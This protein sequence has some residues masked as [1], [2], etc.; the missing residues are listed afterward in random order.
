MANP[1]PIS[2][3]TP[4]ADYS[5]RVDSVHTTR[6]MDSGRVLHWRRSTVTP[7]RVRVVWQLT[8]ALLEVFK[9]WYRF[10]LQQGT[11][12]FTLDLAFG[13]SLQTNTARFLTDYEVSH[14]NHFYWRVSAE[15]E[16]EVP[17]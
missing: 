9:V 4:A 15:L 1:A 2:L 11:Q 3:P 12:K 14:Q 16:V 17:V 6:Q 13:D 8:D 10:G 5:F 7:R